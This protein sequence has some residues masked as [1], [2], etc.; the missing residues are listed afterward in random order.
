MLRD[1]FAQLF[2]NG[3]HHHPNPVTS[4][5][6]MPSAH[7]LRPDLNFAAKLIATTIY[8]TPNDS[9]NMSVDP[10]KALTTVK[11]KSSVG[12]SADIR[13]QDDVFTADGKS[14]PP[15]WGKM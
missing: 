14:T 13:T 2:F 1:H 7:E 5:L 6:S 4:P 11:S 8:F 10:I 3:H 9:P 15:K 12:K